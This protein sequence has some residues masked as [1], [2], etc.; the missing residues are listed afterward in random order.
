M[1]DSS[2]ISYTENN[3]RAFRSTRSLCLDFFTQTVRNTPTEQLIKLFEDA[4]NENPEVAIKIVY[5]LRDISRKQGNGDAKPGKGEKHVSRILFAYLKLTRPMLY[6]QLF[7]DIV[8][9]GSWKDLL[10]VSEIALRFN[11]SSP[12]RE[13]QYMATQLLDDDRCLQSYE[14]KDGHAMIS[15]AGKWAPGEKT[16]F[17]HHPMFFSKRLAHEMGLSRGEYRKLVGGLRKHL[18]VLERLLATGQEELIDFNKL[19]SAAHLRSKKLFLR[20]TNSKGQTMYKREDLKNRYK[21]YLGKLQ[22]GEAKINTT[23]TQPHEL[24]QHYLSSRSI[25]LDVT[26]EEMWKKMIDGVQEKGVMKN[27]MAVVDVSGSMSGLP[28]QVAIALG[29]VV[30]LSTQGSFNRKSITFSQNPRWYDLKGETLQEQVQCLHDMDW[31]YNTNIM[32]VFQLLLSHAQTYRLLPEQMVKTL[33]V[34]TDMQFDQATQSNEKTVYEEASKLYKGSGYDVPQ[35]VFWNLRHSG[36]QAMPTVSNEPGVALVSGFSQSMMNA[37]LEDGVFDPMSVLKN[38]LEPYNLPCNP[39]DFKT[40]TADV[41]I[42]E[43][44]EAIEKSKLKPGKPNKEKGKEEAVVICESD[45]TPDS[46][47]A[48][49]TPNWGTPVQWDSSLSSACSAWMQE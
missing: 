43:F 3:S 32:G 45:I 15:L 4:F 39:A 37:I 28:M 24:V 34:F 14:N 9:L 8:T 12:I 21:E 11:K 27:T 18:N 31:G 40:K 36:C 33:F 25:Q 47:I 20:D 41:N 1:S 30:S 23:G 5:N 29:I 19:P 49:V 42:D 17:D 2:N 6:D 13:L 44:K 10:I 16:H 35:I 7:K 48:T 26:I 38:L 22:R 46:G